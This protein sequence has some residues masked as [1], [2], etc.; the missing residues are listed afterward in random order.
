MRVG[1]P[2]VATDRL[3]DPVSQLTS[4]GPLLRKSSLD[5]LPQVW[6]SLVGQVSFVGPRPA[7]FGQTNMIEPRR[8]CGVNRLLPGLTGWVQVNGRDESGGAEK[9]RFDTDYLERACMQ[10]DCRILLPTLLRVARR[11]GVAH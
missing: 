8:Q 5:E 2:V 10:F 9:V 11:D 1:R 3:P 7:L 6:S 4:A